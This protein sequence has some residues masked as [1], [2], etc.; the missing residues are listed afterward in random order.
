MTYRENGVLGLHCLLFALAMYSFSLNEIVYHMIFITATALHL[1]QF[2]FDEIFLN[3]SFS[4][5]K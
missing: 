5:K 3:S 1:S 4:R 2:F